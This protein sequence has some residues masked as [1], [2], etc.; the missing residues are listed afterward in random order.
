MHTIVHLSGDYPDPFVPAKT[1][2]IQTLIDLTADRFDHHVISLNRASPGMA[3]T[4]REALVPTAIA[5]SQRRFEYGTAIRYTAPGKGLRHKT[6]LLQLG[7][8]LAEEI[9]MM[10][11]RP[12]LLVGH[13]LTIE[14]IAVRR[15]AQ[16][17][18]IPYGLSIQGNSDTKVLDARPDLAGE[19]REVLH[20]AK[21]VFPFAPWAW[22]RIVDKLGPIATLL[23]MLPC[24][25]DLDQPLAPINGGKGL[26]SVFHLAGYRHKN[27]AGMVEAVKVL[28]RQNRAPP[29]AII[30]AGEADDCARCAAMIAPTP[31]I[32]LLGGKSRVD[33]RTAMN[34]AVALVLPSLRETF[35]MVFIEALFAGLP[36]IYPR[37]AAVDGYFDDA[38]FALP[39]EARDP[40]SIAS[41]MNAAIEREREMKEALAG[42]QQ[43]DA[44]RMFQRDRIG[45]SFAA[46]L[47]AALNT[48]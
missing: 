6:K 41:A 34:G 37:G 31:T 11:K 35:G 42:W 7:D 40:R 48:P 36:I 27:L 46:G 12:A 30:G 3:G 32:T 29:L 20:G 22:R 17:T 2:A 13:K 4:V 33:V 43:S 14:G 28:D 25:T 45:E 5:L 15:A 10:P 8:W 9:A 16:I 24:A 38:P 39:V 18:G 26:L 1:R 19:L 44:I 23:V 21:V 47:A